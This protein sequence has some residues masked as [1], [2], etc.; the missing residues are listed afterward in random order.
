LEVLALDGRLNADADGTC[1][2]YGSEPMPTLH[3]IQSR[4]SNVLLPQVSISFPMP[5]SDLDIVR[6]SQS[7]RLIISAFLISRLEQVNR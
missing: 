3:P 1:M 2:R 6:I 4:L 7:P 5:H